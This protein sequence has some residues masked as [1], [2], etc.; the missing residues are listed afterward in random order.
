MNCRKNYWGTSL[1]QLTTCTYKKKGRNTYVVLTA[2]FHV[3]TATGNWQTRKMGGKSWS[4][5]H[6]CRSRFTYT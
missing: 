1:Q 6:F 4:R 2:C 5:G 3:E